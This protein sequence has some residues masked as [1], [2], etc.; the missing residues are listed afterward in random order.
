MNPDDLALRNVRSRA[1][2]EDV[3]EGEAAQA[4]LRRLLRIIDNERELRRENATALRKVGDEEEQIELQNATAESLDAII[5]SFDVYG[6]DPKPGVDVDDDSDAEESGLL[7][8][9]RG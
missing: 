6:D 8:R 4:E 1:A 2:H 5:E 7:G 9:L 3:D